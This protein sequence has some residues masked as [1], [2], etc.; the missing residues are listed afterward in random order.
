[1]HSYNWKLITALILMLCLG[2]VRL[3]DGPANNEGRV[4]VY[5]N[6]TWGTVCDDYWDLNDAQV[7]CRQLGLG[8]AVTAQH[9]AFYG[10][11]SGQIWLDDLICIGNE[12]SI[13]NCTHLGWGSHNCGHHEDASVKCSTGNFCL[14]PL[15]VCMQGV[16]KYNVCI[17]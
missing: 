2:T 5:Y 10:E 7:V 13:A 3:V 15:Y 1:M 8:K 12:W 16:S 17:A 4:E 11:G 9:R 14:K 6:G